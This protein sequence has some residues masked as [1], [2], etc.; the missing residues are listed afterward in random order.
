MVVGAVVGVPGNRYLE[1]VTLV[2]E[3]RKIKIGLCVRVC[4]CV[5]VCFLL[6]WNNITDKMMEVSKEEFN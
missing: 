2:Q 6:D 3:M 5:R 4:V 1:T